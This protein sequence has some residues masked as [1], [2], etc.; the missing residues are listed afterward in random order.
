MWRWTKCTSEPVWTVQNSHM[1][2][3]NTDGSSSQKQKISVLEKNLEQLGKAHK[4]V[5]M[6]L[7]HLLSPIP[8]SGSSQQFTSPVVLHS[9]WGIMLTFGV[10]FPKWK[11]DCG[12]QLNVSK[13]WR[14]P[15]ER[16]R[17]MLPASEAVTSRRWNVLRIQSNQWT[18]AG[19][20]QLWLVSVSV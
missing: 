20:P 6:H 13:P 14:Q 3:E 19:D 8:L 9:Y 4:Q 12:P 15:W 5:R 10:K 2:S 16:Q 7:T 18:W 17:R 1:D 11:S